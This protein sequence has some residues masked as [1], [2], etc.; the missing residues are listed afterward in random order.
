M[1]GKEGE[2]KAEDLQGEGSSSDQGQPTEDGQGSKLFSRI[3]E[4][5]RRKETSSS[6]D[7]LSLTYM[8]PNINDAI[9]GKAASISLQTEESW[10][11]KQNRKVEKTKYLTEDICLSASFSSEKDLYST[12]AQEFSDISILSDTEF[13]AAYLM[14]FEETL[15]TLPSV[16]PPTILAYKPES[17]EK[18]RIF[19]EFQMIQDF[20]AYVPCEFCERELKPFP[21]YEQYNK[22]RSKE[23]FCCKQRQNLYEFLANEEK[24]LL[25]EDKIEAIS[26]EPHKPYI[27][28]FERQMTFLHKEQKKLWHKDKTDA[29]STTLYM[30]KQSDLESKRR[31]AKERQILQDLSH[32]KKKK[33]QQEDKTE[34]L[35]VTSKKFQ[36]S[37]FE[38]QRIKEK[39]PLSDFSYDE[40][41]LRR[42]DKT[43]TLSSTRRK[44]QDSKLE[45]QRTKEKRSLSD[46]EEDNLWRKDKTKI[47]SD[48]SRKSPDSELEG[49]KAKEKR[50][51]SDF[52]DEEE[53]NL[54]RKDKI[55][56]LL[57][58]HRTSQ[59]SDFEEQTEKEKWSVSE[60]SDDDEDSLW[61]KDKKKP[62]S[63]TTITSYSSD[64]EGQRSKEEWSLSDSSKDEDNLRR[65]DKTKPLAST[66][67]KSDSS[68]FERQRAKEKWSVSDF[69]EDEEDSLS[70]KDIT[71]TLSVTSSESYDSELERQKAKEKLSLSD[72]SDDEDFFLYKDKIKTLSVAARKSHSSER[73]RQMKE[74]LSLSEDPHDKQKKLLHKDKTETL[75]IAPHKFRSSEPER[76]QAKAKQDLV[77]SP[78]DK[79]KSLK[80]DDKTETYK[81]RQ[82]DLEKRRLQDLRLSQ[83]EEKTFQ[84]EDKIDSG[85][86]R[87]QQPKETYAQRLLEEKMAKYHD[88]M[89]SLHRPD[90]HHMN[91][92]SFNLS[93]SLG[94]SRTFVVMPYEEMYAEDCNYNITSCDFTVACEKMMPREFVEKYYKHGG[95]FLTLF[96]DGTAQLFYPSGN[97]AI[98]I[99]GSNLKT[100]CCIV[101]ADK[102]N[103]AEIQAV[104]ESNGK[105]TCYHPNGT[106]WIN[107]N[108]CGGQCA[109]DAGNRVKTW[110]WKSHY[111]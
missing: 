29:L 106:V 73:E 47:L 48:T 60:F 27:N 32:S 68:E 110:K 72:F 12:L 85:E 78:H 95:K 15:R 33:L 84:R 71:K 31:Q 107:L 70:R 92:I 104:F 50:S 109:D 108:P 53:D 1:S 39:Q 21:P 65:K 45:R 96:P 58:A 49:Q 2:E 16:G 91:T 99:I 63:S 69:S 51:L 5:I 18:V 38:R 105:A 102:P 56:A 46:D 89:A 24:N 75:S 26:I 28:E 59:D 14:L 82:G 10:L 90:S 79:K 30:S 13:T 6:I 66:P 86:V 20:S 100:F 54:R 97:L 88:S 4:Q 25:N 111:A 87:T 81:P 101:Y 94:D 93:D 74:K 41:N 35:S 76:Q 7:N 43:K 42:E 11:E 3:Q 34:P 64:L 22:D 44:P 98:I 55:K 61:R 83:A 80:Q 9:L 62:L 19:P 36:R 17:S 23:F 8:S 67:H 52:S 37:E 57:R 103:N 77:K 40:D